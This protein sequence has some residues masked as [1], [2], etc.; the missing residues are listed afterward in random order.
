MIS[1][2]RVIKIGIQ[3]FWRNIWLSFATISVIT[4]TFLIISSLFVLNVAIQAAGESI[5]Q[6]MDIAV[7]LK[8]P[9]DVL[10]I[11][12][13]KIFLKNISENDQKNYTFEFDVS[14]ILPYS[15]IIE[16]GEGKLVGKKIV[17]SNLQ[18]K[19]KEEISLIF[20]LK[21]LPKNKWPSVTIP[22]KIEE[23]IS[24][25]FLDV[26][27]TI[28]NETKNIDVFS[29][30]DSEKRKMP[31]LGEIIYLLGG[32]YINLVEEAKERL[33]SSKETKEVTYI[34]KEVA[35]ERFKKERLEYQFLIEY[36]TLK[37]PLPAS[38]EIKVENPEKIEEIEQI[39]ESDYFKPI[40]KEISYQQKR[41]KVI[42]ERLIL[43]SKFVKTAGFFLSVFFFIISLLIIIN[44]IKINLFSRRESI[45]IM[46]LVGASPLFIKGPFFV[47]SLVYGLISAFISFILLY[48]VLIAY[49]IPRLTAYIGEGNLQVS[50]FFSSNISKIF[51]LLIFLGMFIGGFSSLLATR[52]YLKKY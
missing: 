34:S 32:R 43:I 48:P 16:S 2:F 15:Q 21:I 41:N 46:K 37:N 1:I 36:A 28:L 3:D 4:F 33:A 52:K 7:S 42:V 12:S 30:S 18:I 31:L 13:Y 9:I 20:K 25:S 10:D 51:I 50:Q 24:P 8:D 11:L 19:A 26:K 45:E 35:L 40:I 23:R 6:K 5:R 44:T 39:V 49:I 17:F 38:L 14:D 27:I 22:P 29:V 47:E